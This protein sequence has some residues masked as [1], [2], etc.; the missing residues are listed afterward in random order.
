MYFDPTSDAW[1]SGPSMVA[2]SRFRGS[3]IL[4]PDGRRVLAV[5]G[6]VSRITTATAE[7]ADLGASQPSWGYTGSMIQPRRSLNAVLLP[8]GKVLAMGGNRGTGSYDDPVLSAEMYDPATG[9][10]TQMA[11]QAA[12]RAYHSTAVL[13]PDGRVLSAG[14]TNG[15][16]QTTA[17]IYFSSYLFAG[18]RPTLRNAPTNVGFGASFHADTNRAADVADVVL[19]RPGTVTHGVN[20]D[21]RSVSLPFSVEDGGTLLVD[22]PTSSIQAPPG[23]Y[24]M[25]LV[26][27]T[28]VPSIA[29]W[30]RIS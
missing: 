11:A 29:S 22:A 2:G 24:M 1:S 19:I 3:A 10:W 26:D 21:Q 27:N 18:P 7:L 30:V 17:E 12:P 25:F 6:A 20:F 14:Q 5:G 13:L 15:V 28:G 23:W 9:T 8:D 16:M 4:L